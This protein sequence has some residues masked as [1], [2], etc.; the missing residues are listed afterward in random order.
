MSKYKKQKLQEVHHKNPLPE[1]TDAYSV[2]DI[3]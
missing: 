3:S 2:S 1:K